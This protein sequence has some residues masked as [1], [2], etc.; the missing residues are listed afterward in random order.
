MSMF[1][2][3]DVLHSYGIEVYK[4]NI[5][6]PWLFPETH[7]LKRAHNMQVMTSKQ[8]ITNRLLLLT[9]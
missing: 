6:E 4:Q 9:E 1:V 3:A 7:C 8:P 2:R 5:E